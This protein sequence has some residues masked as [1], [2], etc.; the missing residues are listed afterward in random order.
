MRSSVASCARLLMGICR[1]GV[2]IANLDAEHGYLKGCAKKWRSS[3]REGSKTL[4]KRDFYGE[5]FLTG[6]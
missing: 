2:L 6:S 4:Q 5:R 1:G 3:T